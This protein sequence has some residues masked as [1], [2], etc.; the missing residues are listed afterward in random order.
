M[1]W[2]REMTDRI[3]CGFVEFECMWYTLWSWGMFECM[4]GAVIARWTAVVLVLSFVVEAGVGKAYVHR[5][6]ESEKWNCTRNGEVDGWC[7]SL[8]R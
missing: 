7:W 3:W 4:V 6:D 2:D 1:N 5:H 8:G